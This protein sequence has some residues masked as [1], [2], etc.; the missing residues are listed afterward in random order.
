[1]KAHKLYIIG[2]GVAFTAG[3]LIG[4]YCIPP[5][6]N[7]DA[8]EALSLLQQARYSHVFEEGYEP[9]GGRE[10]HDRWVENYDFIINVVRSLR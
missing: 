8:D 10:F 7:P 4:F 3:L 1:M 2:W 9:L 5:I 6:L